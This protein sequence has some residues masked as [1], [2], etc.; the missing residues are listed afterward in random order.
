MTRYE[1][2]IE[3]T[4][5]GVQRD[6]VWRHITSWERVNDELWPFNM[7]HA[8][9]YPSVADVPA[10]SRVHFVS[11][12]RLGFVPVDLHRL[13]I[14]ARV[15]GECF[16]ERSS[17]LLLREWN[18]HRSLR[19]QDDA[20]IV[21]DQCSLTPRLRLLGGMLAGLYRW[22]FRRRHARLRAAF[23]EPPG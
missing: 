22:I 9:A 19:V 15:D 10:D 20:V 1:I 6:Q 12:L 23:A 18:H 4:L 3:S 7:T 11:K 16:D 21:R 5:A 17:N 8:D 14:H 2:D 13:S